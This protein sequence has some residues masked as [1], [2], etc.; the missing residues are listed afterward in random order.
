MFRLNA[1]SG[2]GGYYH[3]IS[4]D[5][6]TSLG[7]APA[8]TQGAAGLY[9]DVLQYPTRADPSRV[10]GRIVAAGYPLRGSADHGV[11][12][13]MYLDD[14]DGNDLELYWRNWRRAE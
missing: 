2:A 14:P 11:S 4:L 12:E 3:H 13:A 8:R 1:V 5:T 6:W 10:M 9:R 7:R